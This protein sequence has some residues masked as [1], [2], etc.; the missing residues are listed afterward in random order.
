MRFVIGY[1]IADA[2]ITAWLKKVSGFLLKT[3][4]GL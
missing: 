4:L 3:L 1:V 2:D